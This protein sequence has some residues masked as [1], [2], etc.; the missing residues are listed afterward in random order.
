M[1]LTCFYLRMLSFNSKK[2]TQVLLINKIETPTPLEANINYTTPFKVGLQY[3][4]E[5]K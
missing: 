3:I 4:G 1:K 5:P 2:A